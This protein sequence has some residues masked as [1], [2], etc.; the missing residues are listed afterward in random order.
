M[1]S[2]NSN[3]FKYCSNIC[4]TCEFEPRPAM[5]CMQVEQLPISGLITTQLS[6]FAE[7]TA[8][9]GPQEFLVLLQLIKLLDILH[10]LCIETI[11]SP[12]LPG[13][14][15]PPGSCYFC[16][17]RHFHVYKTFPIFITIW[18]LTPIPRSNTAKYSVLVS[19]SEMK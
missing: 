1:L 14:H 5:S 4:C 10:K 2:V 8:R 16:S 11:I 18:L 6:P 9:L 19:C 7:C 15:K 17:T 3:F 13:Q 12:Y